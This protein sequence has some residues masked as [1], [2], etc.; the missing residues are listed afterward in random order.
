MHSRTIMITRT[1][2][3]SQTRPIPQPQTTMTARTTRKVSYFF[4][5]AC[6]LFLANLP[7]LR[8]VVS[9]VSKVAMQSLSTPH[10]PPLSLSLSPLHHKC[11]TVEHAHLCLTRPLY[12]HPCL[13]SSFWH[14]VLGTCEDPGQIITQSAS[15]DPLYSIP[16]QDQTGPPP[17][18]FGPNND[19]SA[20]EQVCESV[21]EIWMQLLG[22]GASALQIFAIPHTNIHTGFVY[23]SGHGVVGNGC[24]AKLGCLPSVRRAHAL[25]FSVVRAA[26]AG[27][28]RHSG[29]EICCSTA[30]V[31]AGDVGRCRAAVCV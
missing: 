14:C 16:L 26:T 22:I 11:G 2:A 30:R 7:A 12:V 4:V 1:T 23:A 29:S 5:S 3:G 28:V 20:Y 18:E 17:L 8:S 31:C 10:P 13:F 25:S 27:C 9:A 15:G 6:L 21:C 19:S 24:A